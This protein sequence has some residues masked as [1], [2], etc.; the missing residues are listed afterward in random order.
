VP[1][2]NAGARVRRHAG[3][4]A[5]RLAL[6]LGERLRVLH[7][8]P[9]VP[10]APEHGEPAHREHRI[11][12]SRGSVTACRRR[13]SHHHRDPARRLF[14]GERERHR[15]VRGCRHRDRAARHRLP[16]FGEKAAEP[17]GRSLSRSASTW[18]TAAA[19]EGDFR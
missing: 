8:T 9:F 7:G 19:G 11:I 3:S 15:A 2:N 12:A 17:F 14:E 6:A 13:R 10:P 4:Q 16:E 18:H 5:R 1:C